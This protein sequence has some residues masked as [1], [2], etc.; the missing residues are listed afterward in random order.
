LFEIVPQTG[1]TSADLAARLVAGEAVTEGY[2]LVADRQTAGRGR[3]GRQWYD[4]EGNF[5]GSTVVY[6]RTE[7]P[8]AQT[9]ALLAG[10]SLHDLLAP[11]VAQRLTLK[12]PNDLL[13]GEAKLAGILLERSG[14]AVVVGIGA[15][16]ASAPA[17][18]DRKTAALATLGVNDS[19]DDFARALAEHFAADLERWRSY[20][21]GP[22]V[23]RWTAAGHPI[24]TPLAVD[25]SVGAEL[26]GSFAG[27]TADGALQL[28]LADGSLRVI[29]AGETRIV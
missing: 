21:L 12:W 20:G 3:Q 2:W 5:M 16:L 11:R 19:R 4:G 28:R 27:L 8:P 24:G 18:D 1:S 26:A 6:L 25:D 22:V 7:D 15:N 9:L 17:L 10:I 29:H 13:A 14:N 23:S